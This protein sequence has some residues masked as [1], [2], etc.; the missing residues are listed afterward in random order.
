MT[1]DT[2]L[3][4]PPGRARGRCLLAAVACAALLSGCAGY[5]P[6][7]DLAPGASESAVVAAMGAPTLRLPLPDGSGQRLVYA[8]GPLGHHTWMVD[9]DRALRVLRWH[10]ALGTEQ[11]ARVPVGMRRDELLLT[12]GPPAQRQ[13]MGYTPT[14]LWSYRYDNH[15]CKWHQVE[16]DL[17]GRV[18]GSQTTDDPE[19][20]KPP[21]SWE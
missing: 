10:Q 13:R 16:L 9:V 15:D 14:E 8:R 7:S 18:V 6:P 12:L 21:R 20:A 1:P 11:F 2:L 4:I 19:C 17:Q 5:G 3:P